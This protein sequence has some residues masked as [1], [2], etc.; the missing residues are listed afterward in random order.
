[1]ELVDQ[2]ISEP[3]LKEK[4]MSFT[5]MSDKQNISNVYLVYKGQN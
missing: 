3:D 4:H 5:M 2:L 1:M